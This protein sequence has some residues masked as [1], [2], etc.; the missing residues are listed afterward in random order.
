M[1]FTKETDYAVRIT[2]YLAAQQNRM[3]AK[4]I[5]EH[6][7]VTLRFALKILNKLVGAGLVT[8]Y[9]GKTGGYELA[10]PPAQIDLRQIVE[11]IEGPVG[12]SKCLHEDCGC[13][14]CD[15]KIKNI[16]ADI[17]QMVNEKLES[18]T[19]EEFM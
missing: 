7:D 11:T 17:A 13:T 19:I 6:T 3:P 5:A 18:H 14:T 15:C 4:D 2:R 12:I 9:K 1:Y 16:Y 10:A 8:S